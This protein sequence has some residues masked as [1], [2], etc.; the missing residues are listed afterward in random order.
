MIDWLDLLAVQG[1]LKSV[2]QHHSSIKSINFLA[3]GF[4]YGPTVQKTQLFGTQPSLWSNFT[5]IHGYCKNYSFDY[6]DLC[7]QSNAS[8]F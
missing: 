5:S 3:L 6:K 7:W 2:L 4:L 8:A 1:T